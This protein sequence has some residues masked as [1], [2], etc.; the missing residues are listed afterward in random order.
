MVWFPIDWSR[1]ST[2]LYH[3]YCG[4]HLR[5]LAKRHL[6]RLDFK[7]LFFKL[8]YSP[9]I[10]ESSLVRI[11]LALK[12]ELKHCSEDGLMEIM[13]CF[14]V[15]RGLYLIAMGLVHPRWE[16][17]LSACALLKQFEQ[18]RVS[19]ISNLLFCTII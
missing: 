2:T 18:N 17:Q 5:D 12:D 13:G 8:S 19:T 16:V 14:P 4:K 7:H 3:Q 6:K 15:N 11:F 9:V 1:R 10:P